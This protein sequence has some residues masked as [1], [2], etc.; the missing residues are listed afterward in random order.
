MRKFTYILANIVFLGLP[1]AVLAFFVL[2]TLNLR[3][4]FLITL[5]ALFVGGIFDIWATRQGKR[6]KFFIWEY[7]SRPILGIKLFGVPIED[8]VLFMILTPLF[9]IVTWEFLKKFVANKDY[10]SGVIFV[11]GTIVIIISYLLAYKI[12]KSAKK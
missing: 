12:A 11:V 7:N 10:D 3:N 9:I 8:Y 1:A 2:D 4:I 6:D 5:I